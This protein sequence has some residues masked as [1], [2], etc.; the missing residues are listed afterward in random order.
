[1]KTLITL[2]LVILCL[3][4]NAQT[5]NSKLYW[6]YSDKVN[7]MTSDHSYY[8]ETSDNTAD[9]TATITVRYSK[10]KNDVLLTVNGAIFNMTVDGMFF[11]V[12]FDDSKI[13]KLSAVGS[14]SGGYDT[15]FVYAT[16]SFIKK[17]KASKITFIEIE[18]YDHGTHTFKFKTAG[19][20]W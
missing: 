13:E 5:E 15:I 1:M 16:K 20:V 18:L 9:V 3:S 2:W 6:S 10:G 4:A 19:L 11:K 17:L 7:E 12:K 14:S 8:A